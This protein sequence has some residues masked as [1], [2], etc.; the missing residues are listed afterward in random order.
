MVCRIFQKSGTGPQNGAQYG[1]PFNEEEWEEEANN[2]HLAIVD[3]GDGDGDNQGMPPAGSDAAVVGNG[4]YFQL[5]DFAENQDQGNQ[6]ETGGFLTVESNGQNIGSAREDDPIFLVEGLFND[7]NYAGLQD[8]PS[9]SNGIVRNDG[10]AVQPPSSPCQNDGFLEL[11]DIV[12]SV[13][14]NYPSSEESV[15]CFLGDTTPLDIGELFDS[16]ENTE[17]PATYE[18][19]PF[20]DDFYLEPKDL[21]LGDFAYPSDQTGEDN[22]IFHD[23]SSYDLPSGMD[24]FIQMNDLYPPIADS[25]G[26]STVEDVSSYFDNAY[27][28]HYPAID[29]STEN[30]SAASA[31]VEPNFPREV[32]RTV[33]I[34]AEAF[35]TVGTSSVN[36]PGPSRPNSLKENVAV[37]PDS[38]VVESCD[39]SLTKRLVNM[40]GSI[41]A[42]PAYAAEPTSSSKSVGR[43]SA[44]NSA[45]SSIHVTAGMIQIRGFEV[46]GRAEHWS[47][48][49][50][51]DM[52][53]LL[54]CGVASRKSDDGFETVPKIR[55]WSMSV[56]LRGGLYCFLLSA[57]VLMLCFKVGIR[58]CSR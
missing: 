13:N 33:A 32:R 50:N 46:M 27:N 51:G 40:L 55:G 15:D 34:P 7:Q 19:C 4:E 29:G 53:F 16:N 22:I 9:V 14:M 31:V 35:E 58:I 45:S 30:I 21:D 18:M 2:M 25:V 1:A 43:M 26:I 41:S 11:N 44:T 36:L 12:D 38:R 37:V 10:F 39:R 28:S 57:L 5:S 3:N 56:V 6:F 54:S 49:R 47:M 17:T 8:H 48:H 42:P 20:Q 23:A 52:G 24:T